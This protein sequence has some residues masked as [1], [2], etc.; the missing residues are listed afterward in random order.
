MFANTLPNTTIS[1]IEMPVNMNVLP[2]DCQNTGSSKALWK[3]RSP[4]KSN[5]GSPAV[6]SES[7]NP[8]ARTNGT[9][10]SAMM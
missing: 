3:L 7:A 1:N 5:D 9:P 10:T 2:T 8:T 4:T 6:T